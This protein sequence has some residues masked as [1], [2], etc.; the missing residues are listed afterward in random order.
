MLTINDLHVTI[1]NLSF[2]FIEN[3]DAFI[4]ELKR[5]LKT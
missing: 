2:N 4:Q 1:G 3:T 5:V